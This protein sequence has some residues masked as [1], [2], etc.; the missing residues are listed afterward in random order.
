MEGKRN[1]IAIKDV[2]DNKKIIKTY[3][4]K[5]EEWQRRKRKMTGKYCKETRRK[6]NGGEGKEG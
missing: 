2:K 5:G 1:K 4:H 6:R 3:T